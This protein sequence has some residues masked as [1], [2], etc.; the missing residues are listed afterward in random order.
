MK[1]DYY[2]E[3]DKKFKIRTT[4]KKVKILS[5]GDKVSNQVS[6]FRSKNPK[7]IIIVDGKVVSDEELGEFDVEYI[8]NINVLKGKSAME[9]YG[10]KGKNGVIVIEMKD[11]ES[12]KIDIKGDKITWTTKDNQDG[13]WKVKTGVSGYTFIS[14]DDLS[15]NATMGIITKDTPNSVLDANKAT[16]KELGVSVK[17]SKLRRNKAGEITGIKITLKNDQGKQSSASYKNDD[18]ISEIEYGVMGDK[19]IVRSRN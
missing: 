18:G 12:K 10:D 1:N 4:D 14:T 2:F 13:P 15:E 16:L 7:P 11:G 6:V 5:P 17:Y 9:I 19:L 8:D 3:G